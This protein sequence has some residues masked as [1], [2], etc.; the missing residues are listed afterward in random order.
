MSKNV[1][2]A[3]SDISSLFEQLES[4]SREAKQEEKK[5]RDYV[6]TSTSDISNLFEGLSQLFLLGF[7]LVGVLLFS[8]L[9]WF[10]LNP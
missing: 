8:L 1:N 3:K 10:L 5:R 4:V 2:L 9:L 6:E 7:L